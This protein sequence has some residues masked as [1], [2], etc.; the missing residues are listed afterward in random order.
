MKPYQLLLIFLFTTF[1][2]CT[3]KEPLKQIAPQSLF[4]SIPTS[5]PLRPLLKEI[6][7]ITDSKTIPLH[8]WGE[9][10]SGNPPQLDLISYDGTVTKKVYIKG[11]ANHGWEDMTRAGNELYVADIGDNFKVMS[12]HAIYIFTE[13]GAD[14]D[15]VRSFTKIRFRYPDGP[16][17]ADALLV[18]PTTNA[19]FIITKSA[20]ATTPIF[21]IE[22][23]YSDTALMVAVPAGEVPYNNITSAAMSP[24]AKELILKTYTTLY[25]YT[26]DKNIE[27][28]LQQQ[29]TKLPYLIEPQGEA[30]AFAAD[31]SGF[32]TISE[33]ALAPSVDL[34]FY[35]RR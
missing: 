33:K 24:D 2:A 28:T 18:E 14:V 23:P 5:K 29:P 15:T 7:G 30:I 11:A 32:F 13:P 26:I 35:K 9:E 27:T 21:K 16:H 20:T 1:C 25:H 22:A 19:I 4:D 31:N 17:D 8:L 6:S 10:D 12:E 3:K 34:Y